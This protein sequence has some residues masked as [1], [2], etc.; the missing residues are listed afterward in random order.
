[1]ADWSGAIKPSV[2]L[3]KQATGYTA[4][5]EQG[6]ISRDRAARE[7]TGTKFSKNVQKLARENLALAAAMKPIKEL[8]ALTKPAAQAPS[9]P[10]RGLAA[11]PDDPNADDD[12]EKDTEE[13]ALVA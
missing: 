2:D 3:T 6:F 1:L 12:A 5:V 9:S 10:G 4:L 8:E 7:T 13:N 11:V